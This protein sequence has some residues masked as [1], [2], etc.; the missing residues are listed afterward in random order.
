VDFRSRLESEVARI[1]DDIGWR[2]SYEPY[3]IGGSYLPDFVVGDLVIEVKPRP[4]PLTELDAIP[5]DLDVVVFEKDRDFLNIHLWKNGI[6]ASGGRLL[7]CQRCGEVSLGTDPDYLGW[8]CCLCECKR[9]LA[10]RR[11][12]DPPRLPLRAPKICGF[13]WW[14][15]PDSN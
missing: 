11:A 4:L 10:T 12:G 5:P 15:L 9:A 1:F 6:V 2:W 8:T 3:V 14:Q 13:E 7:V